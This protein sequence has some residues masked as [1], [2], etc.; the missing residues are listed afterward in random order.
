MPYAC[1]P[2]TSLACPYTHPQR[3]S[4]SM[5]SSR[6]QSHTAIN[7]CVDERLRERGSIITPCLTGLYREHMPGPVQQPQQP[8][9]APWHSYHALCELPALWPA[10]P[11]SPAALWC[12]PPPLRWRATRWPHATAPTSRGKREERTVT[13]T[14]LV[15]ALRRCLHSPLGSDTPGLATP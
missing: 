4:L 11:L 7:L 1:R 14:A 10:P 3:Q 2:R 6:Q 12:R 9:H 5:Q 8:R 13:V 15:S